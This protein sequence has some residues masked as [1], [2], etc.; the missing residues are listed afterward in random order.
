[1]KSG[2]NWHHYKKSFAQRFHLGLGGGWPGCPPSSIGVAADIGEQSKSSAIT[3]RLENELLL[4]TILFLS[5]NRDHTRF[6]S[7]IE[8]KRS[9]EEAQQAP[10]STSS[11]REGK[12][13]H[14]KHQPCPVL[15]PSAISNRPRRATQFF[16]RHR[17]QPQKRVVGVVEKCTSH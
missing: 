8:Y 13:R 6:T 11:T 9:I 17:Q 3:V 12:S 10:D 7:C 14:N 5:P 2:A 15:S 16:R 1:V 4:E